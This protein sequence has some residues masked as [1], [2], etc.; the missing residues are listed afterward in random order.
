MTAQ[1]DGT[2]EPASR[3]TSGGGG[4]GSGMAEPSPAAKSAPAVAPPPVRSDRLYRVLCRTLGPVHAVTSRPTVLHRERLPATG[5]V[6]VASNHTSVYDIN[7]LLYASRP[8]PLDYI[9]TTQVMAHPVWG[10]LG[11]RMHT[12]P[13]KHGRVNGDAVRKVVAQLKEGRAVA[14]FPEGRLADEAESV[15]CGG[16]HRA[17]VGR[18]AVLAGVPVLPVVAFDTGHYAGFVSWLPLRRVRWGV[19]YGEPIVPPA[20]LTKDERTTAQ[21]WVEAEWRA[22]MVR[23]AGELNAAMPWRHKGDTGNAAAGQSG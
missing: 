19:I 13:L 9:T 12:V 11:R 10:W 17:G 18:M 1:P 20:A 5:G 21:K 8:R 23:L 4:V 3:Q 22:A 14:L 16:D 15:T 6:L 2:R 7:V